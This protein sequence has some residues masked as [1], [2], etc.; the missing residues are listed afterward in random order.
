MRKVISLITIL[1]LA[2][3]GVAYAQMGRGFKGEVVVKSAVEA[4]TLVKENTAQ[5]KGFTV[6]TATEVPVRRG[7]GYKVAVTD[8]MQNNLYFFVTPF[9]GV[10]GPVTEN[11]INSIC[12]GSCFKDGNCAMGMGGPK[13]MRGGKGYQ[14]GEPVI[15]TADQAKNAA[16]KYLLG[17]KGYSIDSVESFSNRG[18][19]YISYRVYV[20]DGSDNQFYLHVNPWG[21]VFGLM[22]YER[23]K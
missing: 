15:I 7:N 9:G 21:N 20:K 22:S 19:R 1:V 2:V 8:G 11:A 13:G 3:T 14:Q 4:E 23:T 16:E 6:G 5:L 10:F 12:D 18:G 17:L